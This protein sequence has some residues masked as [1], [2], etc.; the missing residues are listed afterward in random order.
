MSNIIT[1]TSSTT[2]I[3]LDSLLSALKE[4]LSSV[5]V[6]RGGS[7]D[8]RLFTNVLFHVVSEEDVCLIQTLQ[9]LYH[10]W[11]HTKARLVSQIQP[12]ILCARLVIYTEVYNNV[13]LL[14]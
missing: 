10:I 6:I 3:T 14:G 12:L 9:T 1:G 2:A 4:L 5:F 13:R 7:K 8:L 11:T